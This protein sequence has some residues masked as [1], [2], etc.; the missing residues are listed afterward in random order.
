MP[1]S[2][3]TNAG[4][5]ANIMGA[6]SNGYT[7]AGVIIGIIDDG[8]QGMQP[9]LNFANAYS[10]DFEETQSRNL[11]D[12][13]NNRGEPVATT[14]NHGTAVA[15]VAAAIGNGIGVT[16][17]APGAQVASL[18]F[19][20]TGTLYAGHTEA[21]AEAA[22]I[23]YEGQTNKKGQSDP[24]ASVNWTNRAWTNGVPVRVKNHSY[25]PSRGYSTE[26][27]FS[28]VT[29]ALA[30]A[31]S[32]G[33][34]DVYAA[35]NQ[36]PYSITDTTA[37]GTEDA[38]KIQTLTTPNL[39]T[40]AALGSDGKY[41]YYSS[42]GANVFV[43]A[44]S[45]SYSNLYAVPTT[46]RTGTNGYN[47]QGGPDPFF[48]PAS[49]SSNAAL[50]DYT[51]TFSGTSSAAPLIS[52]IMALGVQADTN[53]TLRLAQHLLALTSV[54]VDT[55]SS[56]STTNPSY[57]GGWITNAAGYKFNNNYGFG[58]VNATA[59]TTAAANVASNQA[60][61]MTNILS[62]LQ[63]YKGANK[64]VNETFA[65]SRIKN[66]PLSNILNVNYDFKNSIPL[67][68]EYVQIHLT[69]TGLQT[70]LKAYENGIGAIAGDFSGILTSPSGT[71][72]QLFSSDNNVITQNRDYNKS[73][74]DW[75]FLS[76]AYYGEQLNGPWT[77]T[78][79]DNS[80]NSKY[81]T[82]LIWKNFSITIGAGLF[83]TNAISFTN[84]VSPSL[85]IT[86]S[87]LGSLEPSVLTTAVIEPVP[88]PSEFVLLIL[89][90][91]TILLAGRSLIP[92]FRDK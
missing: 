35:G 8:V 39:I 60:A 43:T 19:L 49:N 80:T 59:F 9:D 7:G 41:A 65:S 6:W 31:S 24:Y 54:L 22:A 75:T 67:P 61:G 20:I 4:L 50:L 63:V 3:I 55:N 64:V 48:T 40:V 85:L 51:S 53:M 82:A 84:S 38:N 13:N 71:K 69:L 5:D 10:W 34:I 11:Q 74:I 79:N 72:D 17:A 37:Y 78:L 26:S 88:E 76:Y 46:D 21:Q 90:S 18:R 25:G 52:G 77:L 42:Y 30:L 16:G 87:T 45:G 91:L 83:N 57:T 81:T 56:F 29:N 92:P 2:S 66:G 32:H 12:T 68:V 47:S 1:T 27:G 58:L 89:G 36:R 23:L 28:L 62:P 14:N 86:P 73:S 70:N 33:V 15:G 44:P